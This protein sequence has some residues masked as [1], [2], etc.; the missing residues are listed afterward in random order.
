MTSP[1]VSGEDILAEPTP[2]QQAVTAKQFQLDEY[3]QSWYKLRALKD[4]YDSAKKA[5]E[6]ARDRL[7]IKI[8]G[9]DELT[10]DGEVVATHPR[11]AFN[12]AKFIKENVNLAD[13]YMVTVPT[14][15]FDED[16]FRA[17]NPGLYDDYRS[18]SLR[19]KN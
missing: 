12:K 5:Y 1:D 17:A 16:S 6:T 3:R 9:F 14:K 4:A 10:L 11:G 13:K 8:E 15:V 19:I 18:R 2:A 7:G